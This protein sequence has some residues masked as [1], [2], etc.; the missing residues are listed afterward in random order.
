MGTTQRGEIGEF[1][2][3]IAA[4]GEDR[5]W[6]DIYPSKLKETLTVN[7]WQIGALDD[8]ESEIGIVVTNK[9]NAKILAGLDAE[10]LSKA[11]FR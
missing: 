4:V 8:L 2:G 9:Q 11:G 5:F 6:R 3:Y 7:D 10:M 1:K